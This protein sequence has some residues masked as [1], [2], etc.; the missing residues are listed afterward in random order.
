MRVVYS[1]TSVN[2][3]FVRHAE[4]NI[5]RLSHAQ[6]PKFDWRRTSQIEAKPEKESSAA[7]NAVF[8]SKRILDAGICHAHLAHTSSAGSVRTTGITTAEECG[9]KSLQL[10][11][12]RAGAAL[13]QLVA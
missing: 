7:P 2:A 13:S 3:R 4:V 1:A 11:V 6:W 5:Q 12:L 8:T 10:G 9:A